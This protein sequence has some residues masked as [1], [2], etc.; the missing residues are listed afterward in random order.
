MT[1]RLDANLRQQVDRL[2]PFV[3][4]SPRPHRIQSGHDHAVPDLDIF[5]DKR[6]GA[7]TELG[8]LVD[9][10]DERR[11]MFPAA[12][13]LPGEVQRA[14]AARTRV[15]DVEDGNAADPHLFDDALACKHSAEGMTAIHGADFAGLEP[16]VSDCL[17]DR[18]YR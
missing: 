12:H 10:D 4:V 9:P 6:Q 16:S 1:P 5:R 17:G 14:S 3:Q 11:N 15:V 13:A 18:G 7:T 8:K 2:A